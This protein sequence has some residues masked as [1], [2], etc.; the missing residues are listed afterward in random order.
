MSLC[1]CVFVC[2]WLSVSVCVCLCLYVSVCVC[3]CVSV[4]FWSLQPWILKRCQC[5]LL[6]QRLQSLNCKTR[7]IKYWQNNFLGPVVS[8]KVGLVGCKETDVSHHP[9]LSSPP[10]RH[11]PIFDILMFENLKEVF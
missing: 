5:R 4:C 8:N 2:L 11:G 1:L 6:L 10:Y 9:T 7:R 3:F